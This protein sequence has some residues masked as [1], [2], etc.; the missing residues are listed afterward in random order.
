MWVQ[1]ASLEVSLFDEEAWMARD[2]YDDEYDSNEEV[3][4]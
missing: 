1:V 3:T 4:A 2:V